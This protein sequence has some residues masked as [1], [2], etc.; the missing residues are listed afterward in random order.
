MATLANITI[1]DSGYLTLSSGTTN[2]RP[3]TPTISTTT[4]R[5]LG[6]AVNGLKLYTPT[7]WAVY[8]SL[9]SYLLGLP[10]TTYINDTAGLDGTFTINYACRVYLLRDPTWSAVDVTGYTLLE[11]GKSYI[12]AAAEPAAPVG[13]SVYYRDYAAG[14][15]T[16]DNN[17]AIYLFDF[18]TNV[19]AKAGMMRY[20]T[21]IQALEHFNGLYWTNDIV[22]NG[23]MLNLDV[24]NAES[25][26][27]IGNT[28]R[29]ISGNGR[30]GSLVNTP[31]YSATYGGVLTFNG[32]TNYVTCANDFNFTTGTYTIVCATRYSGATRG[33][34]VNGALN[35]W[36][37]GQW[38]SS[39]ENYYA[40]GWVTA[41]TTGANDTNW[42]I[43]AATGNSATDTWANYT[44]AVLGS[45]NSGGSQGPN[46][47][48]IGVSG[49]SGA[50]NSEWSTGEFSFVLAYNRVLT[51]TEIKQNFFA[52]R[53][54][55]GI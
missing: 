43:Y 41:V 4:N 10:T 29:D 16:F 39:T 33:R 21:D 46:G 22:R 30:H 1:S 50:Y 25:Y 5:P 3:T 27:G 53:N 49:N 11:S 8:A 28:L 14:T 52:Y 36:L 54:R 35:N 37:I 40:E 7:F 20:N 42:R 18:G 45:S 47:L 9:P 6:I 51:A 15:Y 2:Q 48:A 13:I 23:L 12:S 17:Q 32:S 55:F 34:M 19:T 31:T 24:G 38:G 26:A 44:N